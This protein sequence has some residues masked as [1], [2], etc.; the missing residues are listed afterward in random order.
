MRLSYRELLEQAD[1]LAGRLRAAGV[2]LGSRVG[3]LL[4]R[5][6]HQG[7]AALAVL[8]AG[9]AYVP[10]DQ[11]HPHDR[12]RYMVDISGTE[13]LLTAAATAGKGRRSAYRASASTACPPRMPPPR[14]ARPP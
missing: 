10:L 3:L 13:L 11:A 7:I 12:L 9:G 5:S 14:P 2:R 8:R 6:A 1:E 4:P